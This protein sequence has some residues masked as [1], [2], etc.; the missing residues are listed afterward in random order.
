[1]LIFTSRELE[2]R[3]AASAFAHHP[4]ARPAW[5]ALD[6]LERAP[7]SPAA[8]WKVSRTDSDVDDDDSMQDLRPLFQGPGPLLVYLQGHKGTPAACFERC[9]RLQSLYGLEVVRFSWTANTAR[10]DDG[11]LYGVLAGYSLGLPWDFSRL[12]KVAHGWRRGEP[13]WP[14]EPVAGDLPG[15]TCSWWLVMALAGQPSLEGA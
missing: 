5:L 3:T 11:G 2:S 7:K 6:N 14:A 15:L 1:M 9:D 12:C 8:R 10:L 13:R 4:A